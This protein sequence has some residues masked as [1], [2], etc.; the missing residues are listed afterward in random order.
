MKVA[1]KLSAKVDSLF[2][3]HFGIEEQIP[4]KMDY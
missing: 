4:T 1:S 2:K 3:M